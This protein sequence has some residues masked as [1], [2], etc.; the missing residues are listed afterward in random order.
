MGSFTEFHY[1]P[2]GGAPACVWSAL[3]GKAPQR[4]RGDE[5]TPMD[6]GAN[7]ATQLKTLVEPSNDNEVGSGRRSG[8]PNQPCTVDFHNWRLSNEAR[9]FDFGTPLLN[10]DRMSERVWLETASVDILYIVYREYLQT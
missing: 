6:C 8:W 4:A 1:V 10:G 3:A 5:A 2:K 9:D 7:C